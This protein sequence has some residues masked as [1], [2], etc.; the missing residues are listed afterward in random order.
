[1]S[2]QP[3][4]SR[5]VVQNIL[6]RLKSDP[7]FQQQLTDNPAQ[8]LQSVGFLGQQPSKAGGVQP[9]LTCS[10]TCKVTCHCTDT[11]P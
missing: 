10:N 11:G 5:I 8:A 4:Q 7:S 9:H 3:E 6:D 2:T 1:M